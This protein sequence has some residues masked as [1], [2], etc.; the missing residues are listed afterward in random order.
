MDRVKNLLEFNTVSRW[1]KIEFLCDGW[2]D[3]VK[4]TIFVC[5]SG[6]CWEP[7]IARTKFI[8][9]ITCMMRSGAR[10]NL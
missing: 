6:F 7:N 2:K 1:V 8:L 4:G 9:G 5:D 3:F 10:F